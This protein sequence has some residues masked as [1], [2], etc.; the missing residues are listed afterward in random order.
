VRIKQRAAVSRVGLLALAFIVS[1]ISG[2]DRDGL[3]DERESRV[4]QTSI[5]TKTTIHMVM[6]NSNREF[7]KGMDENHNPYVEYIESNT[8]VDIHLIIPPFNGY[9]E[10]LNVIMTSG[11]LPD[12]INTADP[13]WVSK[14]VEDQALMPLDELLEQHG[15]DLLNIFPEEAWEAVTF[16]GKIYAVPSLTEVS[17]N[18]IIYARKDW[19]DALQLDRPQTLDEYY[20]V[21]RAFTYNDPDGNGKNDTW[22][23]TILQAGLSRTA[24]FFG[25][26]GVPRSVNQINQ[27]KEVNGKL[28]YSGILPETKEALEY[29]AKLYGAGILD[30]EFILNKTSSFEEKIVDGRVGLFSANWFDTRGP[31]L[32]NM[33]KNPK[34][35]WVR[36]D[37]PVGQDGQ[38]GTAERDFLQSYSV[39]PVGSPRAKEVIEVL[40][41]IA[42]EGY[43]ELKLGFEGVV[44]SKQNGVM[45][46][47]FEAHVEHIYRGTLHAIVDPNDP[48]VR[49]DRLD[50]LGEQYHLNDNVEYV[51]QHVLRSDFQG[52]PTPSMGKYGAKLSK[53]EEE[54]FAKIIMGMNPG[55]VFDEFVAQWIRE[56]GWEITNEVNAWYRDHRDGVE[57][58]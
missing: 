9:Q 15:Q 42:G 19:L 23:L 56:G 54:T 53:L 20:E 40:N 6:D 25:A 13:T 51:L 5:P 35:E 39:I 43:R 29:F 37:Y 44:W 57:L 2:C 26:F 1:F 46:T 4:T 8:G 31:I 24:P 11:D 48:A 34:A 14:Y 33:K 17:G 30:R 21:M 38:S 16:N 3:R 47:D 52:P 27:W 7:P 36:L 41:F 22:G 45:I 58:R 10:K 12:L 49:K 32:E 55:K 18:E 28:V 50:S